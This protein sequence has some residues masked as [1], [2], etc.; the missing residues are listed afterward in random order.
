MNKIILFL[1]L[2]SICLGGGNY[3]LVDGRLRLMDE[4]S[5][6]F[7]ELWRENSTEAHMDW[8]TGELFMSGG[9]ITF[10]GS[11]GKF[12]WNNSSKT[13]FVPNLDAGTLS[14]D[15]I[16]ANTETVGDLTETRVVVAGVSG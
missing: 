8:S 10:D 5:T 1:I 15:I 12:K 16:E 13:L 4:P 7:F 6:S 14:I 11:D 2:A 9:D 3:E